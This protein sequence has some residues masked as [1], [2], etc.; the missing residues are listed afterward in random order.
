M[1]AARRRRH[2]LRPVS[3]RSAPAARRDRQELVCP[4][5]LGPAIA[6]KTLEASARFP[7]SASRSVPSGSGLAQF[8]VQDRG[9]RKCCSKHPRAFLKQHTKH[10]APPACGLEKIATLCTRA[11]AQRR[12]LRTL[13]GTGR[14]GS[15]G[16][17]AR[18]SRPLAVKGAGASPS[19]WLQDYRDPDPM[20]A[21]Q[22]G[23]WDL[24][25]SRW[26]A[27]PVLH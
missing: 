13:L 5:S 2:G 8:P 16:W 11:E 1:P 12:S 23:R 27:R 10:S 19:Y 15:A 3:D 20:K 4:L 21:D 9:F 22:Y 14:P 17:P 25:R 26:K 18:M 24:L 7:N 6:F